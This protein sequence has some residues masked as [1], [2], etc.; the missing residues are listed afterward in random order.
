MFVI[1]DRLHIPD[2]EFELSFARSSGPGGQNVNKVSSKV[3]LKWK[4]SVNTS[5]PADVKSRFLSANRN[6][7]T[8]DG[9]FQITSEK[10]R[11]QN[12][13][14]SDCYEKLRQAILAASIPPKKRRAT[15][16]TWG[17]QMRRLQSK[18]T[19][20]DKKRLRKKVT[21]HD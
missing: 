9:D 6:K 2:S 12:K 5:L 20:A 10:T 4:V 16:P 18:K 7:I 13:N 14:I 1:N 17:S 11:D 15:E 8:T 3:F 19:N 21:H